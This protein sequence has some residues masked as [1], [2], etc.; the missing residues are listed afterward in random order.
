MTGRP[1]VELVEL[2][3]GGH[4]VVAVNA[5]EA[6][7]LW[8]EFDG[9]SAYATAAD[10]LPPGSTIIDVGAHIGLAS[11]FFAG[12]VSEARILAFE[13]AW[14]SS[15][16]LRCNL[17]RHVPTAT[18]FPT[19]VGRATGRAELSYHPFATATSTLY[20][21]RAD[22]ERNQEAFLTNSGIEERYKQR[23]REQPVVTEQATVELTTVASII[24]QHV[25]GE[26]GL[27]KIDVE[28]AEL[29]VIDGVRADQWPAIRRVAV[30]VHDIAGRL[31]VVVG[32]LATL[33]F[34][35]DVTQAR[36]FAGGSVYNVVAG[37]R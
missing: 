35:V 32:R 34:R 14:A 23:F 36:L 2:E 20:E 31:G 8:N 24:D 3:L 22:D 25:D 19:A 13:P 12:R 21:D 15:A 29:D 30:E 33:G 37:R 10:G 9:D 7:F 28:R 26:V 17:A 16:C 11:I 4:D 27:L 1:D 18:V 6:V 5:G